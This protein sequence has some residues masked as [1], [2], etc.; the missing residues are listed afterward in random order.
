M[1]TASPA[2]RNE[3]GSPMA[4]PGFDLL[5]E[6]WV[7][8]RTLQGEVTELGLREVFR[9]AAEIADLSGESPT[10]DN[11][12]VRFLLAVLI[13]AVR[14]KA[15]ARGLLPST[16]WT[17]LLDG[18]NYRVMVDDYLT[19]CRARF[20]LF[21]AQAPFLQVADLSTAKGQYGDASALIPD[22]GPGLFSTRTR[23]DAQTLSP[24][25]AARWLI[26]LH[27][28]DLSGIKSGAVGDARVKGGKGYPIGTGWAGA[29]GAIQIVGPTLADTLFLNLPAEELVEDT[30]ADAR[31]LPPWERTPDSAAPRSAGEIMPQGVVDV[32]TWQQRRVRLWRSTD[33]DVHQA[34]ITNGDKI[35]RANVFVDPMTGYRW[36]KAQSKNG[37]DVSFP[38]SHDPELTVWRGVQGMFAAADSPKE[39]G[40]RSPNLVQLDDHLSNEIHKRF[41]ST[42]L[43]LRLIGAEYGTQDAVLISEIDETIPAGI[44]LLDRDGSELRREATAAVALVMSFRGS[45]RWFLQQLSRCGGDAPEEAPTGAVQAWM[46]D[47]DREFR[48]WIS[49]LGQDLDAQDADLAWRR[50]LHRVS[51]QHIASAVVAAGPA[52]AVGRI[53]ASESGRG[54]LHSSARYEAWARRKLAELTQTQMVAASG[55]VPIAEGVDLGTEAER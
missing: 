33:G 13:R 24:A 9:R 5:E 21:D 4:D 25:E 19:F 22:V 11:A 49:R 20:D 52:A 43:G 47:M 55:T 23:H 3:R 18:S 38:R 45:F 46:A 54:T 14:R 16:Y 34:L 37:I 39:S 36:S 17:A 41:G 48:Q 53:E 35:Q 1:S 42:R 32:L 29:I 44:G 26:R 7:R 51:T 6:P 50:I 30:G 12:V 2:N 15:P 28:Y 40:R 31:D 10:Q 27:A 8:V